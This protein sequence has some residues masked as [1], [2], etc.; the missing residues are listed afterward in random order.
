MHL[1]LGRFDYSGENLMADMD[2][3]PARDLTGSSAVEMLREIVTAA[4]ICVFITRHDDFPFD[5]RPMASQGVDDD[6]TLWF[7]SSSESDKNKDIAADSRVTVL[8]QNNSKYQYAQVS[9]H[10]TIH[11]DRAL[12]EKY[13]TAMANAW[14]EGKD[15]PRVTLIAVHPQD[16]HYWTTKDGKIVAGVKMLL[17]AAGAR[18]DDGGVQGHLRM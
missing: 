7:L 3:Q 15:D 12:I 17:G 18:V 13:W 6:G 9:G 14:F 10:A 5:A 1:R 4:N 16:G 2:H 11:R 8:V